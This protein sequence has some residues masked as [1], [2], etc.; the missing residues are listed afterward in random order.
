[1]DPEGCSAM[2]PECGGRES[3][4]LGESPDEVRSVN[5]LIS[6]K[7]PTCSDADPDPDSPSGNLMEGES[8]DEYL[9]NSSDSSIDD[10]GSQ[11]STLF[12]EGEASDEDLEFRCVD[13]CIN[14]DIFKKEIGR[15]CLTTECCQRP[16]P[17]E[18]R[19]CN[20]ILDSYAVILR[21]D[22]TM[23]NPL[24]L[25]G[26][27]SGEIR[28][29]C[30]KSYRER[31][32]PV[33]VN[34]Y[35]VEKDADSVDLSYTDKYTITLFG[36]DIDQLPTCV[37]SIDV[38]F[39]LRLDSQPILE[40][41]S[42]YAV[43]DTTAPDF[44]PL[45]PIYERIVGGYVNFMEIQTSATSFY[46]R[47]TEERVEMCGDRTSPFR[48]YFQHAIMHS[49]GVAK[50]TLK[51]TGIPGVS[52]ISGSICARPCCYTYDVP[53]VSDKPTEVDKDGTIM[54]KRSIIAVPGHASLVI[55]AGKLCDASGNTIS[56]GGKTF[57][58][59]IP[60]GP[61]EPAGGSIE[62]LQVGVEWIYHNF[63]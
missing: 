48:M 1:M 11:R 37:P 50:I 35:K 25:K 41:I 23:N 22:R 32:S 30:Y 13:Y 44:D 45:T 39:D 31:E 9:D 46:N 36:P 17:S 42:D 6:I 55:V 57:F 52:T 33:D 18:I 24:S 62:G 58:I 47:V 21:R 59:P 34:L 10:A 27:L 53:L 43:N 51:L 5:N 26:K 61:S 14:L 38:S 12:M 56:R 60:E 3:E 2:D 4:K 20:K 29:Q 16:H 40:G 19:V 63:L 54:L 15:N 49:A 28:T 7:R 8:S